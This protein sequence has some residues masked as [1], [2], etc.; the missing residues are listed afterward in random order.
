MQKKR[1][2]MIVAWAFSLAAIVAAI[3]NAVTGTGARECAVLFTAA[4]A[5]Q[6]LYAKGLKENG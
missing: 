3:R 5:F 2:T 4:L 1:V 6:Y